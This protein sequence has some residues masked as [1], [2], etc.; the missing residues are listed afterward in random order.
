[1]VVRIVDARSG[2][3]LPLCWDKLLYPCRERWKENS[4]DEARGSERERERK[5]EE[6]EG[7][8]ALTFTN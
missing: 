1:V 2:M 8:A 4:R 6:E 5:E 3:L 7:L